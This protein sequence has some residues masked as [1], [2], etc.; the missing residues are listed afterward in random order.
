MSMQKQIEAIHNRLTRAN[1]VAHVV[2]L[3]DLNEP[4]CVPV[5]KFLGIYRAPSLE[6]LESDI[7]HGKQ[8]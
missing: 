4:R 3:D 5:T 1:E 8:G 7:L 2:F 6:D